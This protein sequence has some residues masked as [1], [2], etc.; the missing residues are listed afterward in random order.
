MRKTVKINIAFLMLAVI[1]CSHKTVSTISPGVEQT[2]S[3]K[4]ISWDPSSLKKLAPTNGSKANYC[5]YPRMIQ[6]H[7]KS[8]ICVYEV[9]DGSI[10]S[11]KSID[12]GSS[13]SVPVTI[14][15]RQNGINMAVPEILELKDHSLLASYNPRPSPI[16]SSKHFGIRTK[17]SYDGGL[18]WKDE[19]LLYEADSRFEDGCWEPSQIQLPSGEIQLFFSNEGIYTHSN[20]QNISIFRS[21]DNGL[22]W[23]TEPQIVSFRAGKRDGMPVPVL[24]K[25]KNE[26]LFSI[27][28]NAV[29]N[30][31]PSIIRGSIEGK[32]TSVVDGASVNRNA[33]LA[34]AL[35]DS[36]YAGAP[37]LRQ[38]KTCETILS[39]QG[40][41]G[42]NKNWQQ[43][44]MFVTIGDADGRN[45]GQT[46]IP[47]N[48]P[49]NK[50][51][52]WNS[53]CVLE[54]NTIIALTSTNAFSD[55]GAEVWMIKG[56]L[57]ND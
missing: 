56:H 55:K 39:Y 6:L 20:E 3:E 27:E 35:P 21:M 9:G 26:I 46:S 24:L 18:T 57:V 42:R 47:F 16:D 34:T 40:T 5:G 52:L 15:T 23:T 43:S 8:L 13:W 4:R 36:V 48:V 29:N 7:D 54:D 51:G 50:H 17:K 30:F 28:D 41:T 11:I 38:L 45:F 19:R 2:L 49:I 31:K 12:L 44:C 1:A 14:A 37:Y 25:D 22:S 32:W 33:A 10:E 53:L